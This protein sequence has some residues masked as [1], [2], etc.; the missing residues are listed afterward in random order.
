MATARGHGWMAA[1]ERK[2]ESVLEV[3]CAFFPVFPPTGRRYRMPASRFSVPSSCTLEADQ[4]SDP[5]FPY[6][7]PRS[8]QAAPF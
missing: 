4:R 7:G 2:V 3:I 5:R 8:A 1:H 6:T